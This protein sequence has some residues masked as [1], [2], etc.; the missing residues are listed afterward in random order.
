MKQ[1]KQLIPDKDFERGFTV[2]SQ[3]DHD[4]DNRVSQL[5]QFVYGEESPMPIWKLAQWDSGPCLWANR[6]ASDKYT[7][8]D[9]A[10]RHARY[11]PD[12]RS[13][14]LR[15]DTSAYYK[16]KPAVEGMYWPHLLIEQSGFASALGSN[17]VIEGKLRLKGYDAAPVDGDY[18]RAAQFLLFLYLRAATGE[19]FVWF[20]LHLFDSRAAYSDTYIGYDGGKADASHALIYS[21]GEGDIFPERS[22]WK[23]GSPYVSGRWL[24]FS[25]NLRPHIENMV[26]YGLRD[27]YFKKN[28]SADDFIVCGLNVG[29]ESIGTFDHTME[30][31]DIGLYTV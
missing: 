24:N 16:G 15:L 31:K 17:P 28:K 7:L 6:I 3:K 25:V 20:G 2:L 13:L 18:V 12:E 11:N 10:W 23:D 4:N 22:L 26:S 14:E 21:I 30:I 9:G 19:D 5:G 8:T 29:W 1:L 27:G